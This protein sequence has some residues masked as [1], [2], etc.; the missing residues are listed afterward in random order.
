MTVRPGKLVSHGGI[1]NCVPKTASPETKRVQRLIADERETLKIKYAKGI[2]LLRNSKWPLQISEFKENLVYRV[3]SW[4]IR[5]TQGN[6]FWKNKT[7]E[8]NVDIVVVV[9]A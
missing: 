3:S 2:P 7:L 6:P 1:V 9:I 8:K 4:T 5:A